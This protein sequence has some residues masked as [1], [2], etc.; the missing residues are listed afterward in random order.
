ML[1]YIIHR[2]LIAIPTL[3]ILIILCFYL[4]HAAPGGPFTS[5]RPLPPQVMANIE[6]KYGL[7]QPVYQQMW[8]Y[9]L[10]VVTRVDFG[11]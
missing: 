9:L 10:G 3:L 5:E 11:P 1:R 4:M 8:N 2:L 6:A 7:N